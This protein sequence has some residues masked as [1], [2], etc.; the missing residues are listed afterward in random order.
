MTMPTSANRD[1]AA[2]TSPDDLVQD[3]AIRLVEHNENEVVGGGTVVKD[4]QEYF[5]AKIGDIKPG[6]TS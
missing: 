2:S 3:L 6:S 4:K 1:D 5:F